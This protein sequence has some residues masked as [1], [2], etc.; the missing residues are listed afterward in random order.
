MIFEEKSLSLF[1]VALIEPE[2]PSNTGNIG[3]TCLATNTHLELVGP[4]G[5]E[6]TDKQL[7]RAG[8]DYWKK[9]DYSY[10]AHWK[11]WLLKKDQKKLWFFS[12]KGKR[13]LYEGEF[14]QGDTLVFGKETKGLPKEILSLQPE[15][16]LQIPFIKGKVRSLNLSNAVAVALFEA[17]RQKLQKPKTL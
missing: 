11:E 1:K 2:I 9:L 6:L 5:F 15:R 16:V 8:L 17:L 7:K 10:T 14:K 4:L 12:T 3:R 13:S